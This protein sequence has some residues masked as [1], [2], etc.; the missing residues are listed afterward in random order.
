MRNAIH[1][2]GSVGSQIASYTRD[3]AAYGRFANAQEEA[4]GQQ[5]RSIGSRGCQH[6]HGAPKSATTRCFL[7]ESSK[8]QE[9]MTLT[10]TAMAIILSTLQRNITILAG[11]P[12][13]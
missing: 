1:V 6:Q 10:Y 3:R 5:V 7:V 4:K 9:V 12:R 11:M 13:R 8:W 2:A